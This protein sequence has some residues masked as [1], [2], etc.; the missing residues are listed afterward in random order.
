M[1]QARPIG[2]CV[3]GTITLPMAHPTDE[4]STPAVF[5]EKE[6]EKEKK[7]TYRC[8]ACTT[9]SEERNLPYECIRCHGC[10]GE[11]KPTRAMLEAVSDRTA[12]APDPNSI[13]VGR[14]LDDTVIRRRGPSIC[15]ECDLLSGKFDIP[16]DRLRCPECIETTRLPPHGAKAVKVV[17]PTEKLKN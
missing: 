15:S 8:S 13:L 3:P 4:F 2:Y 10:I 9:V 14:T 5:E 7:E 6:K 16:Y 12:E 1:H 17:M 11:R